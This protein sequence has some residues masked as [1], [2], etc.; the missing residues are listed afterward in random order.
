MV[1]NSFS[2][3]LP[4]ISE[5]T[6]TVT[7][8]DL[9]K[10]LVP[11][12]LTVR[13]PKTFQGNDNIF[14]EQ[15][16]AGMEKVDSRLISDITIQIVGIGGEMQQVVS[17]LQGMETAKRN[18]LKIHMEVVSSSYSGHAFFACGGSDI[19]IRQGASL[20]F[21]APYTIKSFFQGLFIYRSLAGS[22]ADDAAQ[23]YMYSVCKKAGILTDRLIQEIKQGNDVTVTQNKD[24]SFL[25]VVS[26]DPL[27]FMFNLQQILDLLVS[28][29]VVL[30]TVG[31]IKRI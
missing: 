25:A 21:H 30:I 23:E 19:S 9:Q 5:K 4:V 11:E 7:V 27:G 1:T 12:K 22:P 2:F 13:V 20:I 16:A 3:D 18:G 14:W 17:V 24:G 10:A 6:I 15:F 8:A 29:A 28:F 26:P 31:L